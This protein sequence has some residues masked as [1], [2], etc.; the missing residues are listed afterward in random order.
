MTKS[1]AVPKKGPEKNILPNGSVK[2]LL[3][4]ANLDTVRDGRGGIFTWIPQEPLVEFNMLYFKPGAARGF[5]YHPHFIEYLLVADGSGV[6]VARDT[7]NPGASEE[8]F[9]HLS[10]GTCIRTEIGVHH[11][12]YAISEL[13]IIAMLTKC[14][15]LSDPPVVRM[16]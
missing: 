7:N 8:I 2:I 14:W 13:T 5:H 6:Y 1:Q 9:I 11:T 4:H 12:V 10:K 3:P 16:E 15:D